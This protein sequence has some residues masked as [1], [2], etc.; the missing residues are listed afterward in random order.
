[1]KKTKRVRVVLE[2]PPGEDRTRQE[3]KAGT[4]IKTILQRHG[5][6]LPPPPRQPYYA[7]FDYD[8]T[9]QTAIHSARQAEQAWNSLPLGLRRAF[10]NWD[11]VL[12][13]LQRGKLEIADHKLR[14]V[15]PK[16]PEVIK[17]PEPPKPVEVKTDPTAVTAKT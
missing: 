5:G 17:P 8:T 9:L 10:R 13:A 12:V 7:E 15:K 3:F 14:F 4:D 16:E 1:M 11:E 2:C 6:V